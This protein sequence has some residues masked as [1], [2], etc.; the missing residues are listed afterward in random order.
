MHSRQKSG[1]KSR[2]LSFSFMFMRRL[3][4]PVSKHLFTCTTC[5][6]VSPVSYFTTQKYLEVAVLMLSIIYISE[7][8]ARK[9]QIHTMDWVALIPGAHVNIWDSW[10]MATQEKAEW[11]SHSIQE[12]F[13]NEVAFCHQISSLFTVN[14]IHIF[15]SYDVL[16]VL[17]IVAPMMKVM[18]YNSKKWK[19]NSWMVKTVNVNSWI[20]TVIFL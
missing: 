9:R 10:F 6:T 5:A 1:L 8:S 4:H 3:Q 11:K 16:F 19:C 7:D 18:I 13:R 17:P 15:T 12:L 20:K 14:N 2:A